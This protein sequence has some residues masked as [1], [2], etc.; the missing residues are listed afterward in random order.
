MANIWVSIVGG[1]M[2]INGRRLR[3]RDSFYIGNESGFIHIFSNER[4]RDMV[5][6][7]QNATTILNE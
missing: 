2:L 6:L 5:V 3:P 4:K 7:Q 1:K